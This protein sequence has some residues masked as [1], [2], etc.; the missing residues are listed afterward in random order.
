MSA[1][2]TKPATQ[3]LGSFVKF[4]LT[5]TGQATASLNRLYYVRLPANYDPS[6]AYRVVYLGPGCGQ[7]QDTMTNR[8]GLPFESDPIAV[9]AK[10]DAILVQLEPGQYNPAEYN[11]ANCRP[12]NTSG[13]TTTSAYCF[14]DWAYLSTIP[15]GV[16]GVVAIERAYFDLLHKTIEANYCVDPGHQF[17]SGYSS[18]GWLAQQLGC[19]FP[20]VLRAQA[21]VT[22]GLP[23]PIKANVMGANDYCVKKPIAAFLIHNNPDPSNAFSGSVDSASRLFKLNGCTGTFNQPPLPDSTAALPAG[24]E[25]YSV[26]GVPNTNAFRCFKYS[27]CPA[28]HPMVFCVSNDSMHNDQAARAVPAFWEFFSKF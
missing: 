18:G 19:W 4:P 22:G 8:K 9:S 27:T 10:T 2:C 11:P 5:V 21:N 15:D 28:D 12:G 3:A 7:A 14:D 25:A 23:P 26:T 1:G 17:Y 6:H 20:D 13:C 24:L 16:A